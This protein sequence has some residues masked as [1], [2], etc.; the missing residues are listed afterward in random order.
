MGHRCVEVQG[1]CPFKWPAEMSLGYAAIVSDEDV[2]GPAQGRRVGG[3]SASRYFLTVALWIPNSR[4]IARS[5]IPL[6]PG[7]LNRLPSLPLK[8]RRLA[9][10]GGFGLAG[11]G[12]A[13]CDDPLIL[14]FLCPR[15]QWFESSRPAFAQPVGAGSRDRN[16]GG[17]PVAVSEKYRT[18]A[19]LLGRDDA[20][21]MPHRQ[22]AVQSFQ[23]LHSRPDI[24][25]AFRARQQL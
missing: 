19:R 17:T 16:S 3:P 25:G 15:V 18:G 13:V 11:G 4:S 9:P 5:D 8:E 2:V 22:L 20:P 24:A 7:F 21:F 1:K 6:A 23:D 12:R 10:G 14:L